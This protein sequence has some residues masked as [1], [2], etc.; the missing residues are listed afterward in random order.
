MGAQK[1]SAS[2]VSIDTE[3]ATKLKMAMQRS[4]VDMRDHLVL[5]RWIG[6]EALVL[7]VG[8][9][10][11]LL[12]LT[13]TDINSM[14]LVASATIAASAISKLIRTLFFS[15]RAKTP[16]DPKLSD[17]EGRRSLCG[18]VAGGE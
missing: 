12:Y 4:K 14:T 8:V 7:F 6:A 13:R 11:S 18:K 15:M 2:K 10:A 5:L 1:M 17:C 9:G 3:K 16:N